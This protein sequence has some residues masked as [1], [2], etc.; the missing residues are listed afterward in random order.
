M[1][2]MAQ[3]LHDVPLS[4]AMRSA[5]Q[6]LFREASAYMVNSGPAVAATESLEM[7]TDIDAQMGLRWEEQ[8]ALDEAVAAVREGETDRV[9]AM[10]ASPLL[11]SCFQRRAV[12]ANFVGVLIGSSHRAMAEYALAVVLENPDLAQERYSTRSLLH[13][14]AAAGNLPMVTA[15]LKL[16]VDADIQDGGGH[17]PLYC[18]GNECCGG[19]VVVRALVQ[20]GAR[21]DACE[22]VKQCTALHMAARRGN[23]EAAEALL[24]C[25]TNIEARDAA[26]ETPLRRAVNCGQT[27][28]AR[29]LLEKGANRHS[30]GS[31]GL[32]PVSAA[33]GD[34]MREM[35]RTER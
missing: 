14:A 25:G 7:R 32:T 21:V 31:K 9:R 5:L 4:H 13:A 28:V 18:V 26:G 24:E 19:G 11:R 8:R 27:G 15:L 22:G 33:R 35:L 29:L 1:E 16:G 20:G 12:M 30:A 6:A 2:L 10:L 34:A 3:A 17:T 23:V